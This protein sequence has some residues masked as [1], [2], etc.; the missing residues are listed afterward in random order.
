M[1]K[2]LMLAVLLPT[3]ALADATIPDKDMQ[4]TADLSYLQRYDG[5]FI[6]D[7][8][9]EKFDEI[10]L[11]LSKLEKTDQLDS[12]NNYMSLP[13]EK[14][15]LEGKITRTIYVLP[16]E[17]TTLE[18]IRNYQEEVEGK[19]GSVLYQCKEDECGGNVQYGAD[20]GGNETG[21]IQMVYPDAK[22]V[23]E[24]FTNGNC[25]LNSWHANQ[26]FAVMKMTTPENTE[27]HLGLLAYTLKNDRYCKALDGRTI[28]VLAAIEG[29]P[30]EQNMVTVV[31]ADDMGKGIGA[32]G[33]IA[34]YGIYF[35]Y[36]KADLKPDSKPQLEEIAKMLK[37]DTA[38]N[39]L[40]VGHT[41]NQG[42]LA[43]NL[44]LSKRRAESVVKALGA[45]YG[46]DAKRLTAQGVG[47]AAPVASN[48]TEEGRAKNRRVEI[49]KR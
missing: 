1:R 12:H 32:D 15:A 13:K 7:Q 3:L 6:V 40:V 8:L 28:L 47:M 21:I 26:R 33:H 30:R 23:Q 18:V 48:D 37:A 5:S 39:V 9:Q 45:D 35:D 36:N 49:V 44:D 16:A 38:L 41:D 19:G 43:Y 46:I 11:P 2:L 29:K 22:M 34:L 14:L 4:G 25:S 31:P 24:D 42:E 17:R 20:T 27:V 10:T